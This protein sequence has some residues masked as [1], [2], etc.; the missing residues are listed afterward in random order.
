MKSS[1]PMKKKP[2]GKRAISSIKSRL[3]NSIKFAE[4]DSN[5]K[6][7]LADDKKESAVNSDIHYGGDKY[8]SAI[9]NHT[10]KNWGFATG[11]KSNG[12]VFDKQKRRKKSG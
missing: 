1:T 3:R 4:A 11:F 2:G 6:E 12:N 5:E 10:A 8:G 9:N 7:E